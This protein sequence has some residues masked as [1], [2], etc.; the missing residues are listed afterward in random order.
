MTNRKAFLNN[1]EYESVADKFK[2]SVDKSSDIHI[3]TVEELGEPERPS[4]KEVAFKSL[5]IG[6]VVGGLL[7]LKGSKR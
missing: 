5:F 6:L 7:I 4:W 3:P 2:E 1:V